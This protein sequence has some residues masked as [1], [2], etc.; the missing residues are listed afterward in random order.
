MLLFYKKKL[1]L[2]LEENIQKFIMSAN[3]M[4]I[5]NLEKQ[6]ERLVEQLKDLEEVK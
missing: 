6:L 4:L 3:D 2:H 1:F 5:K